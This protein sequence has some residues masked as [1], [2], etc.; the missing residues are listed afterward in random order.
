MLGTRGYVPLL[1]NIKVYVRLLGR[2]TYGRGCLRMYN[3]TFYMAHHDGGLGEH[4]I[5]TILRW[6][7]S[8][9]FMMW[10]M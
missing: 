7:T 4:V 8:G 3:P 5:T 9:V 10:Q 2:V 6:M 1:V